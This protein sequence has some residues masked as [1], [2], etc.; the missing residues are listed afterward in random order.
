MV[1]HRVV[2]AVLKNF[3]GTYTSRYSDYC[4]YWLFG[5]LV[6]DLDEVQFD[7]L[8]RAGG[9]QNTPRAVATL[10]AATKFADQMCKAGLKPSQFRDARLRIKKLMGTTEELVNGRA[11]T[12][13]SVSFLASAVTDNGRRYESEQVKFV[14]PHDPQIEFQSAR[15]P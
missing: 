6:G 1:T 4:G 9:N 8:T 12:G 10:L 3:L 11:R 7:L 13:Y 15:F 2:K 14:A 5:F